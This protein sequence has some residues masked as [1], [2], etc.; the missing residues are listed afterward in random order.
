MDGGRSLQQ[1][2]HSHKGVKAR[3]RMWKRMVLVLAHLARY[4]R[5]CVSTK[6]WCY[7]FFTCHLPSFTFI[8]RGAVVCFAYCWFPRATVLWGY[9]GVEIPQKSKAYFY[10]IFVGFAHYK[11]WI[12]II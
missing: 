10:V 9:L 8:W 12:L 11:W 4:A 6:G 1:K 3:R 2:I 5:Y 7:V